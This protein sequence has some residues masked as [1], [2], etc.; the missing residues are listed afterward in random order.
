M[1]KVAERLHMT[2][3]VD[4][5]VKQQNKISKLNSLTH[6]ILFSVIMLTGCLHMAIVV[7]LDVQQQNKTNKQNT[8]THLTLF[9]VIRLTD[10]HHMAIVVVWRA[11]K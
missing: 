4:W 11:K 3:V 2:I 10:S 5:A 7:D 8:L 1:I 6:L 9:R